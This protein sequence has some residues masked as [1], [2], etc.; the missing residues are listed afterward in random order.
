[1]RQNAPMY[2][3]LS[4]IA[5]ALTVI[6]ARPYVDPTPALA[7]SRSERLLFVEPGVQML[8]L[9]DGNGQIYGKV[10]VDIRTGKVWGFPTGSLDPY[11][12]YPMDNKPA[13]A[14]AVELGR[15]A[16]EDMDK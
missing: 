7:Q 14:H 5:V 13:I 9:P 6:A 4:V 2:F 11:P 1:M 15:F 3:L 16:F 8:R 10:V 12:S